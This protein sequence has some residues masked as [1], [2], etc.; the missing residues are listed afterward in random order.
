LV[1][2]ATALA[3]GSGAQRSFAS[4]D[5]A[6]QALIAAVSSGN[7]A[8]FLS[9]AGPPM[10]M[11][12]NIGDPERD[13]IDRDRLLDAVRKRGIKIE[14]VAADRKLLYVGSIPQAFPAPLIK[15]NSGWRFDG[16]AGAA[17]LALRRIYRNEIAAAELCRRFRDAEFIYRHRDL[18]GL[19][20]FAQKVRSTPG[21]HDGLFWADSGENEESLLGPSFAAAAFSEQRPG[22]SPKPMFGY[23]FRILSSQGPDA[24]GGALDYQTDGRLLKGFA[25][26]AWPAAY[27]VDGRRS[28]LINHLGEIFHNDLGPDT[29]RTV[30]KIVAFN[31][32]S[33]WS[34]FDTDE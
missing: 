11:F 18:G 6:A 4:A 26:I 7:C 27:G 28:F 3:A 34:R 32:D 8:R 24:P 13:V 21:Q 19:Q 29:A 30:E 16:E 10:S 23:F 14:A 1:L 15:T 22:G 33:G 25:L 9:I 17:E 2:F 12:W 20:A 31:P 5:E